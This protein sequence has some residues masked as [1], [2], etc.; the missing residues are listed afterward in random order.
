MR[1]LLSFFCAD[2]TAAQATEL[3]GLDRKTTL[4]PFALFRARMP[5]EPGEGR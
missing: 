1:Q 4:R 5:G 3:S 2:L